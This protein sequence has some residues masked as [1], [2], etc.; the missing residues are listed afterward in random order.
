M[1]KTLISTEL[2]PNLVNQNIFFF[3][4]DV[5]NLI[6]SQLNWQVKYSM[7]KAEYQEMSSTETTAVELEF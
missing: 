7:T 1:N 5:Y 4:S 2:Q 3:F 6:K